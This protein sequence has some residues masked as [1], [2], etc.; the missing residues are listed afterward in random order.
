MDRFKQYRRER[1]EAR[2]QGE[3]A[4]VPKFGQRFNGDILA[5]IQLRARQQ[6]GT[7]SPVHERLVMFWSN[8]F[9]VSAEKPTVRLLAGA[10][11]REAIRPNI[12]DDFASLLL[13]VEQHPAMLLY[14]DN[15]SSIGPGS[16]MGRR[17]NRRAAKGVAS[18]PAS[19]KISRAR[20]WSYIVSVWMAG[21]ASRMSWSWRAH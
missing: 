20:P 2:R 1:R 12:D 14:L 13:S 10:F 3:Q 4:V 21:I 7:A 18:R 16:R 8:H 17:R 9:T 19:M 11:E 15:V 5:E 6:C